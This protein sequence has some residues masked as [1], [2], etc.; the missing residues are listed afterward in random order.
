MLDKIFAIIIIL[1]A[2]HGHKDEERLKQVATDIWDV[3]AKFQPF[4][5]PKA[6][7]AT[8]LA[9]LSIADHESGWHP[10]V[11]NCTY[12]QKD[13]AISL[14][15][16]NGTVAFGGHSKKEI[17]NDNKLAT[18]L[19]ANVLMLFKA[20]GTSICLFQGYA[21]GDAGIKS[22]AANQ[23][24]TTFLSQLYKQNIV[25]GYK[26]KCLYADEI[27]KKTKK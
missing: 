21:S 19:A 2:L 6:R 11:Q 25:V 22:L 18:I 8:A 16:L 5:G 1:A 27:K 23:L 10:K 24:N 15:A 12:G 13:P 4:C 26:D 7:E 17:C 3:S 20:C 9:L 14:F